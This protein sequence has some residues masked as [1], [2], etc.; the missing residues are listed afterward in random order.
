MNIF[1]AIKINVILCGSL[2]G[3]FFATHYLHTQSVFLQWCAVISSGCLAG[4]VTMLAHD[5]I[6]LELA[7]KSK[8]G[9]VY[10]KYFCSQDAWFLYYDR[11]QS[12]EF[13]VT[14]E[15]DLK[16]GNLFI[17]VRVRGD[18]LKG[19]SLTA[20][21]KQA[22]RTHSAG[23]SVEMLWFMRLNEIENRA[24]FEMA[25]KVEGLLIASGAGLLSS[26]HPTRLKGS[27]K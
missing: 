21:L 14:T 15:G 23:V 6:R 24:T 17:D 13:S 22:T 12:S 26:N 9:P 25:S 5:W 8:A 7:K 18:I 11:L 19:V 20:I 27:L 2:L 10:N 3:V 16:Q 4:Y 1:G